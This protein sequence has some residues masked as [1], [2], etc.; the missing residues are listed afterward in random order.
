MNIRGKSVK[1][2]LKHRE[3][4][5]LHF[6]I[7]P[8]L[9]QTDAFSIMC[10]LTQGSEWTK[11]RIRCSYLGGNFKI[12]SD[13]WPK[14]EFQEVSSQSHAGILKQVKSHFWKVGQN[15]KT[16]ARGRNESW[17]QLQ[18]DEKNKRMKYTTDEN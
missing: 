2:L 12:R 18:R 11:L 17:V 7:Q 16:H 13:F 1:W 4:T 6:F 10:P 3:I 14:L 9:A 5:H 15:K 8:S